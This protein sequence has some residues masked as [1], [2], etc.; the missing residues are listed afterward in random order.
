[1]KT[2]RDNLPY[3]LLVIIAIVLVI[4]TISL[5]A[6]IISNQSAEAGTQGGQSKG[7]IY[8]LREQLGMLILPATFTPVPAVAV[9]ATD[10]PVAT[11]SVPPTQTPLSIDTPLPLPTETLIPST[12]VPPTPEPP[13]PEPTATSVPPTAEP[14]TVAPVQPTPA[15]PTAEL[16]TPEPTAAVATAT[17][18]VINTPAPR[19]NFR[20]GYLEASGNC[21]VATEIIQQIFQQQFDLTVETVAFATADNLFATLAAKDEASRVDLTFCYVDPDDRTYLQKHVGFVI[22]VGGVFGQFDSKSYLVLSNATVKAPI[23]RDLPCVYKFLKNLK[24]PDAT[25][26]GQGAATWLEK[27]ADLVRTWSSC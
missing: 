18:V 27:N 26:Q 15:P 14:P 24:F 10:T 20:F 3:I 16:P 25:L 1:M 4:I 7:I 5:Q 12:P 6:S 23:E 13:T 19:A 17:D 22:F 2:I 11:A 21:Q 9:V 8:A